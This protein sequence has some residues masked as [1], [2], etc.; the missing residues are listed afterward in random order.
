VF[1]AIDALVDVCFI[2]KRYQP[3][4][5]QISK[6]TLEQY[7]NKSKVTKIQHNQSSFLSENIVPK[8]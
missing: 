3:V 2:L 8:Y 4:A 5:L 1:A 6:Q 7:H